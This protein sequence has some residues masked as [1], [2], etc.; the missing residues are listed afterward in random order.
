MRELCCGDI[1]LNV[2]RI[3]KFRTDFLE[4]MR[5]QV[6]LGRVGVV[7]IRRGVQVG[8]Q[9]KSSGWNCWQKKRTP[10]SRCLVALREIH[11]KP[12]QWV[13]RKT[14]KGVFKGQ[15]AQQWSSLEKS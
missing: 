6:T 14:K 5:T 15:S 2:T 12:G 13:I 10:Q 3:S 11:E 8:R 4:N 7:Q 9:R 1:N